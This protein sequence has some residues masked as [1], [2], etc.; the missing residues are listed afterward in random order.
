MESLL[1]RVLFLIPMEVK[2]AQTSQR[3]LSLTLN[4]MTAP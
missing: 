2:N 1:R 4:K 3:W